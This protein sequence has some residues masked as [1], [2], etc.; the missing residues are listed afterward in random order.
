MGRGCWTAI[1]ETNMGVLLNAEMKKFDFILQTLVNIE[2]ANTKDRL[3]KEE[4]EFFFQKFPSRRLENLQLWFSG[5][6]HAFFLEVGI[7]ISA[8]QELTLLEK[9]KQ[10]IEAWLIQF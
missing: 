2:P 1:L 5:N 4:T 9:T 3:K 7:L 6:W 8:T 10:Q